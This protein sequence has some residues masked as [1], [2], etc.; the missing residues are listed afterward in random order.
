LWNQENVAEATGG[1][2]FG[3]WEAN[4]ICIDTRKIQP[5][6]LFIAFKG[7]KVD[8]HE[9]VADALAKGASAAV[10]EFIPADIDPTRLILVKNCN[11]ALEKLAVY[12]RKRSL[13][14]II[15]VTGSVGKTSTK[16]ALY[17][18]FSAL[19]ETYTSQ[20][21]YNNHLG[22]P[23]TMASMPISSEYAIFEMGMSNPGEILYLTKLACPDLAIITNIAGVHLANF[24]SE[25][26]VAMAK[27][28]IFA[29]LNESG[30]VIL[31]KES[32]YF[33]T[34]LKEAL[35]YNINNIMTVGSGGS[36]F[37]IDCKAVEGG[38][39]VR[40]KI[41]DEEV[42]YKLSSYGAHHAHNS[43][44]VLLAVKYF[45]ENLKV[46]ANHLIN[47]QNIKGRG[48][49]SKL[50][51][52]NKNITLIDDS[53]NASPM[54]VRAALQ[55]MKASFSKSK[56]RVFVM[57]DM[58]ELG[59]DEISQHELISADIID[60]NIDKVI[61]IGA[62]VQYMYDILPEN[63]K[64]ASFVNVDEASSKI[65]DLIQDQDIIL[66]KGSNGTKVHKLIDYFRSRQ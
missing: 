8:G 25:E 17:I 49:V 18:A 34:Q 50:K 63:I 41:L 10:V 15:A 24:K 56:R 40:A 52:D 16:E 42:E 64:L 36:A 26:D 4:R 33:S 5:H 66:V 29:G 19:G 11:E 3:L 54:S 60:N 7:E 2:V 27:S 48:E 32:K 1:K 47:F 31:N 65:V 57:A 58:Y 61:A 59:P 28:E 9:Y 20:G 30:A 23:I 43:I 44:A 22:L 51:V 46:A 21:N 53:Y 38:M 35:R 14:K 12:N 6:D 13:A 37:L 45:G 62:L 55:S 39:L